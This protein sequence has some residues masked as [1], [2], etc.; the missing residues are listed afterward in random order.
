MILTTFFSH[1]A[2]SQMILCALILLPLARQNQSVK[3]FI[4]LMFSGSGYLLGSPDESMSTLPIITLIGF[5]AGNALPG[6]F[7]LTGLSVFG[8]R[9]ELKAWQFCVASLTL[10]F[11]L[12]RKSIEW[13]LDINF[14]DF[15]VTYSMF[16]YGTMMFELGLIG[17]ALFIAI[18][19]WRDDLVAQR[20]LIRGGVIGIS[21]IY[22]ILVIVFEQ[23]LNI[24]W[25]GFSLIKSV[26]LACLMT[27]INFALFSVK[28]DS[29]F[30][31]IKEKS[32]EKKTEK[33]ISKELVQ[34][35]NSMEQDKIYRQEGITIS[36]LARRLGI[37]EYKLRHL[38]NGE[39]NYRNFNDFLNYYRIKEVTDKLGQ[40]ELKQIPVLTFALES[41][42]R[43]LSSFN[44]TFK[45]THGITPTEYRKR[46]FA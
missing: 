37:H 10:I 32:A 28:A 15:P 39:L 1:F 8:G 38:I 45:S 3:I 14:L 25:L 9:T 29:L 31:L 2:L 35:T 22:L 43:S 40:E 12:L 24:E 11:P 26:L 41:G 19:Y 21:A 6:V 34:I 16:K 17:H 42:F 46:L 30:D 23:V 13:W 5:V 4:V 44:K 33:P 27:G 7:W 20:R 36:D 18:Q